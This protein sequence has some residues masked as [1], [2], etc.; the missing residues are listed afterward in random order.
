MS[1]DTFNVY[2]GE[3]GPLKSIR[4]VAF[5]DALQD[6]RALNLLE[7]YIGYD[8]VIKML[9]QIT[10]EI[11]FKNCAKSPLTI[12]QI[13]ERLRMKIVELID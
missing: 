4:L 1:G 5:R 10:G 6:L 9:E 3:N 11:T 12:I 8:E 13:R 2:P 7:S